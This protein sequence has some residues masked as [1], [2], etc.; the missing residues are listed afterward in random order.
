MQ[1]MAVRQRAS[2]ETLNGHR[3]YEEDLKPF[4]PSG[5]ALAPAPRSI[6]STSRFALTGEQATRGSSPATCQT[7]SAPVSDL[8]SSRTISAREWISVPR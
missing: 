1:P 2:E 4:R 5:I 6:A 8:I 3:C 7:T